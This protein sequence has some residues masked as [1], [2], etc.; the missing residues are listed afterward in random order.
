[1]RASLLCDAFAL[2]GRVLLTGVALPCGLG[3]LIVTWAG[4]LAGMSM[5]TW[6]G[7]GGRGVAGG[8]SPLSVS[9]AAGVHRNSSNS[10]AMS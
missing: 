6:V 5:V 7:W 4:S 1:M 2:V 10:C 3:I 9:M 8:L